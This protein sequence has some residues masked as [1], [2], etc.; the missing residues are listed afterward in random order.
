MMRLQEEMLENSKTQASINAAR[1]KKLYKIHGNLRKRFIEVN[2]FIKDCADKKRIAEK[3]VAEETALHEELREKIEKYKT[4]I[5]ELS[6]YFFNTP[7]KQV[8]K[9][10]S[11]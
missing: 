10:Q 11:W 6:K 9:F 1:I 8:R 4:S 2:N 7:K 3:K 5:S